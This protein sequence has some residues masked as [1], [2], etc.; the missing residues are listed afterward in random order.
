MV[1]LLTFAVVL[2]AAVLVSELAHRSVLSTAV[3]FLVAGFV[4]GPGAL[5]LIRLR[6]D[7]PVVSAFAELA[8]FSVL[9][10]DGMRT[11]ARELLA[12]WRLPGQ[13]LLIGLPLTLL[14]N[15]LLGRYVVGLGWP[16]AFL[17]GAVLSPTD[18]VFA[19]AIVGRD[20]VPLRLRHLLNVESGLNDGLALPIVMATLVFVGAPSQF[21]PLATLGEVAGGVAL[22]VAVPW[23][24]IRLERSRHFKAVGTYEP[25]LAFAIGLLVL[26]L[27]RLLHVNEFL[28][29]FTAGIAVA[30]V[31]PSVRDAFVH[32]GESLAEL[33]KLAALLVFG[34]LITP[35]LL[36][37]LSWR[38]Y[39]FAVL[40]LVA[41]RPL[42]LAVAL[43]G[44]RLD[45][46]EWFA[47]AWF[48]PKGFA[49]VFFG[50]LILAARIPRG[51][52]LFALIALVVAGSI[53]AHASTDVLVARWFIREDGEGPT[54]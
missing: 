34:S 11:G 27:S 35:G 32:L 17:V 51:P 48:G 7:D 52:R 39:A 9:F 38:S 10:T 37:G 44:N 6:P 5:G 29:A 42:A 43:L 3:L 24:A 13:A 54:P 22:G 25:L 2:L 50:L 26:S 15:A 30:T 41:V 53:L 45:R 16:E 1:A 21:H 4:A 12:A 36:A 33:L 47:A 28:A 14:G 19:A 49:S 40:A 31:G 23:V 18:P 46:R 8:L 20:E